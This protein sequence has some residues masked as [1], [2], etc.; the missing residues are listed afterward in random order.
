MEWFAAAQGAS[1]ASA[2]GAPTAGKGA[3]R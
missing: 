1:R 3:R 2:L